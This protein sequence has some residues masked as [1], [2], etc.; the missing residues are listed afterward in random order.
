M[1]NA[2]QIEKPKTPEQQWKDFMPPDDYVPEWKKQFKA[3]ERETAMKKV[4]ERALFSAIGSAL[5]TVVALLPLNALLVQLT[6]AVVLFLIALAAWI[7]AIKMK[8]RAVEIDNK[9]N[10]DVRI[11][12][13]ERTN[14]MVAAKSEPTPTVTEQKA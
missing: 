8:L 3:I 6:I 14:K 9:L 13:L 7:S 11:E 10:E 5:A 12:P 4:A 2:T 1:E